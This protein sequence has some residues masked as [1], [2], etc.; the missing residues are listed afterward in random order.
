MRKNGIFDNLDIFFAVFKNNAASIQ[1][2]KG[3]LSRIRDIDNTKG[4]L[5]ALEDLKS[6]Y[7]N[8]IKLT[9]KEA[10]DSGFRQDLLLLQRNLY[11]EL[12]YILSLEKNNPRHHFL[13][14][15]P[16][17][18]RPLTLKNCLKSLL[19]QC[20]IFQY[21]GF[22]VNADGVS[23]YNKISLFIIDDSKDESNINQI[24]KISSEISSSGIRTYYIGLDEQTKFLKQIPA[25]YRKKLSGLIGESEN[26][27]LS[28]KGASITRNI[29]YLYI[30]AMLNGNVIA[31]RRG[32]G[33]G[34]E[35]PQK[36]FSRE[37]VLIYFIDSDE[38]FR[39]KIKRDNSIKDIPFINYFYW[40]DRI[41][42]SSDVEVLT[43]KV[44]GDPPVSPTVMI[45]T[46]LDDILLFFDTISNYRMYDRC[47][48]H[49]MQLSEA[50]SAEYHDMVKLFGYK[51]S[52][53]PKTYLCSLLGT[54][55]LKDCF[56]DFS[57]KALGFFSGLHP[58][59]TQ[60]Y[61]H[62]NDFSKTENARTVYTGNY[63][64]NTEGFRHFIP[65]AGLRLRM[66]GPTLGRI[67]KVRLK[68]RFVSAN[69]PLLHKRTIP[70]KQI[71]EFRSGI[72]K[73]KEV[74]D[75]SG[76]FC[77]QFWGDVMLFSI[78]TLT[79]SGYPTRGLEPQKISETV[80]NIQK[81]LW[82]LY[83][84]EQ[85]KAVK[86]ISKL[87]HCLSELSRWWNIQAEMKNSVN[88]FNIF[89][90]SAES[91]FGMDSVSRK[92]L[93]EQVREGSHTNMIVNAIHSFYED[94]YFWNKLLGIT[95]K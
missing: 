79:E 14:V 88:N 38:E 25:E 4:V 24:K 33:G 12:E 65:F 78:D 22:T 72:F 21:G 43:G 61:K 29:A 87:R 15:I 93:S 31:G 83:K 37:K 26:S 62:L 77:R 30:Y 48:F 27:I 28:H 39:I 49:D 44:V 67:L 55:T 35:L 34:G 86:K 8:A 90:S 52:L 32:L 74:I 64:F 85:T 9:E 69:L 63:V 17:A 92:N 3:F 59:R 50:F 80:Y 2:N 58:T 16:V 75:L 73:K 94:E 66:A 53:A 18:D 54:H 23:V 19:T 60:F 13:I 76:E 11:V 45:N 70:V 68:D 81:N 57:K 51:S 91:N 82:S 46:F 95:Q 89:C 20:R 1:L 41:F 42:E 47:R 84:E 36:R 56:E 40:L 5:A 7:E 10:A 6:I 71:D